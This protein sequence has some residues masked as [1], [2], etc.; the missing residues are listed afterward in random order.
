MIK[1]RISSLRLWS[2]VAALLMVV[3]M[4][5]QSDA[6]TIRAARLRRRRPLPLPNPVAQTVADYLDFTGN[7]VATNSVTL[8]ARVEGF[9]EKVHF[10]DGA[11]VKEGGSAVYDSARPVQGAASAGGGPGRVTEGG[12]IARRYRACPLHCPGQRG[13]RD[14]NGS[15]PLALTRKRRR[16]RESLPRKRKLKSPSSTSATRR[17]RRLLTD[18]SGRHLVNPGNVVGAMGQ[19]TSLAQIDQIDPIYVYFTINERDLLR[20]IERAKRASYSRR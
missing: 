15:G 7:T 20:V 11:R 18:A 10:T 2:G 6:A 3:G 1:G 4:A 14:A 9:L 12:F 5:R 16:K 17:S 13:C 19:Q 8:V